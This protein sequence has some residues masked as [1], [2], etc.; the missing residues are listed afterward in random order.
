M[1]DEIFAQD[2]KCLLNLN[3]TQKRFQGVRN[4]LDPVTVVADMVIEIVGVFVFPA[5][6]ERE[7][8]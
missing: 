7:R 6:S 3:L 8:F 5:V 2:L 1:F 4:V